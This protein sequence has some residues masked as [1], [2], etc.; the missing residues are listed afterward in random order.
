MLL[1][2]VKAGAEVSI[3][4]PMPMD[5]FETKTLNRKFDK[6]VFGTLGEKATDPDEQVALHAAHAGVSTSASTGPIKVERAGGPDGR[7]IAEIYAQK[8]K[9]KDQNVV[10]VGKVVKV[11][12]NILGKSWVH[13]RDGTG[14]PETSTN[15]LTVT[16]QDST[17]VG[18]IVKVTGKIGIDRNLGMGYVFPV[19]IEDASVVKQ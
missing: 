18:D 12:P 7:T 3:T 4:D 5:G 11:N 2:D 15:A 14:S 8:Q 16:T 1:T 17:A 6:I 19:I 9:L 13:L 10:V